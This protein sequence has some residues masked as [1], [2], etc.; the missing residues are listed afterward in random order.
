MRRAATTAVAVAAVLAGSAAGG[1][2]RFTETQTRVALTIT[3]ATALVDERVRVRARGV[4]GVVTLEASAV[5]AT[6]TRWRSGL[7]FR[8]RR[9]GV[10]DTRGDMRLF[11]SMQPPRKR[12]G[13][14]LFARRQRETPVVIRALADGRP[15]ASATLRWRAAAPGVATMETTLGR[16]GFVGTFLRVPST[17]PKPGVLVLGGSE[18]GH[19]VGR[20]ALLASRGYPALSLAY[21]KEPG[22][23]PALEQI[24]LEYFANALRWLAA[25][26]G[27][28]PHRIVI[29]GVSRGGEAA[30]LIAA[31]YPSLVDAVVACTPSSNVN[32]SF[33]GGRT[34]AWTYAGKPVPEAPIAVERIAGPVLATAGGRDAIW[35]SAIYVREIVQRARRHG[36]EDVVGRIFRNAGHAVG[37]AIPNLPVAP[38]ITIGK[39]G[40]SRFGGTLA[41]NE[42]AGLVASKAVLSFLAR[43][44][45]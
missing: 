43:L 8:A 42:Q 44:P 28:D 14:G 33:P 12:R 17:A 35:P 7:R 10:V 26:P 18:G 31:T 34:S 39:I 40:F 11:W 45:G 25:Q 32:P 1:A 5:D 23:P 2:T 27:V 9:A 16:E 6:R 30:L 20:A 4:H 24:P 15:V 41:A 19:H 37:C 38:W 21:F 3:P 36:R 29:D 13:S 22:L